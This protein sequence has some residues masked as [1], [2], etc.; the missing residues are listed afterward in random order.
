MLPAFHPRAHGRDVSLRGC[1]ASPRQLSPKIQAQH[2]PNAGALACLAA[3][4]AL[5]IGG[6][7]LVVASGIER[8]LANESAVLVD[9]ADVSPAM[10]KAMRVPM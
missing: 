5:R 2:R 7:R 10:S 9:D 4:Q 1:R 3:H 6:E 8:E